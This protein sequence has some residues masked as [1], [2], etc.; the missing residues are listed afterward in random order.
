MLEPAR[1]DRRDHLV[2]GVRE[3]RHVLDGSFGVRRGWALQ[4]HNGL[5]VLVQPRSTKGEARPWPNL[6]ADDV[7]VER[8]R[9]VQVACPDVD[10]IETHPRLLPVPYHDH[11][12]GLRGH[13]RMNARTACTIP[14]RQA[15]VERPPLK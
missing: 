10:V 12:A 6:Q 5:A 1:L 4:M 7:A 9:G 8:R 11:H 15:V 2:E 3:E 13:G 14:V